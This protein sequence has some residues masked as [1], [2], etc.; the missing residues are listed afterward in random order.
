MITRLLADEHCTTVGATSSAAP[1]G[2]R[3]WLALQLTV[4]GEVR[5]DD[6]AVR[7]LRAGG[8][9]LLAVGVTTCSGGFARGDTVRICDSSGIEVARGLVNLT[10][11]ELERVHGL[12]HDAARNALGYPL[13]ATVV[14][15]QSGAG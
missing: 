2:R 8:N 15:R 10:E 3:R 13:P 11:S 12:R 9:S 1:T 14:L 5:I 4:L 7:A 6:K